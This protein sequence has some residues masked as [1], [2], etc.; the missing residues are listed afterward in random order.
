MFHFF[1]AESGSWASGHPR[2]ASLQLEQ[3]PGSGIGVQEGANP[4]GEDQGTGEAHHH[5]EQKVRQ[6]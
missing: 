2:A 1:Q 3:G 4:A 5:Q 6:I